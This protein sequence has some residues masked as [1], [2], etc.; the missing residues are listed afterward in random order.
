MSNLFHEWKSVGAF[1]FISGLVLVPCTSSGFVINLLLYGGGGNNQ[2]G[3]SLNNAVNNQI[4]YDWVVSNNGGSPLNVGDIIKLTQGAATSCIKYMGSSTTS[5]GNHLNQAGAIFSGVV[6]DCATCVSNRSGS[7]K[8]WNCV[9]GNCVDP[10]DG[11]GQY[12]SLAACQA[13]CVPSTWDCNGCDCDEVFDGSGLYTT[14]KDC[15][16]NCGNK[17]N[18][19]IGYG[20]NAGNCSANLI[21]NF[22]NGG[23]CSTV[24]CAD[25]NA[26][27]PGNTCPE[28]FCSFT[29][30]FQYESPMGSGNWVTLP[31]SVQF[32]DNCSLGW[33]MLKGQGFS[34]GKNCSYD[35]FTLG[36]ATNYRFHATVGH[37][38]PNDDYTYTGAPFYV[39]PP[40]WNAATHC[41]CTDPVASNF[42]PSA[43][44]DDG[45]CLYPSYSEWLLCGTND[46]YNLTDIN[47]V[48]SPTNT[49]TF[50][51]LSGSPSIG[52]TI[53]V[54]DGMGGFLCF[55]YLGS[56]NTAPAANWDTFTVNNII[57][58][59]DCNDCQLIYGCTDPLANNYDPT[60]QIDDGSCLYDPVISGCTDPSAINNTYNPSAN[61][62]CS[63]NIIGSAAYNAFSGG[64][65]DTSCC[66]YPVVVPGCTDPL[67]CNYNPAA[68]QD[69]GSCCLVYG[70]TDPAAFNYDPTACCDDGS[71]L[72]PDDPI[73][74]CTDP[75]ALN[76]NPAATFD[77]GTCTYPI[78]IVDPCPDC[79]PTDPTP[80]DPCDL[81]QLA[82][83]WTSRVSTGTDE[84]SD[85]LIMSVVLYDL[86]NEKIKTQ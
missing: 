12:S 33:N 55:E 83:I 41:G 13:A 78:I 8:S 17:A 76:Y 48:L 14:E 63:S 60:A 84:L 32:I 66:D 39:N 9:S 49:N 86:V 11:S 62:D 82:H 58:Y 77:D 51:Q 1:N 31:G 16:N 30:E 64:F 37:I 5:T 71:C 47:T 79:D 72:Y 20:Y 85:V 23:Y 73:P 36:G 56:T 65:G 15:I 54:D 46:K 27:V 67:A 42:D 70:C 28:C 38:D 75:L 59:N 35:Q 25:P 40:T 10:N 22:A 80:P 44:C 19:S 45:S 34:I 18:S 4:F 53:K 2:G 21:A 24:G 43:Q 6:N 3:M 68:T 7:N 61:A 29:G 81:L 26:C 50:W 69:D 52:Q 74:G 57:I